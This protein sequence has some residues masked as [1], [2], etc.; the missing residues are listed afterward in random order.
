MYNNVISGN[1]CVISLH[2][3]SVLHNPLSVNMLYINE[4]W[5]FLTFIDWSSCLNKLWPILRTSSELTL[6]SRGR[7][8]FHM[9]DKRYLLQS[10]LL[11][12][13][14][15][16]IV[17]SKLELYYLSLIIPSLQICI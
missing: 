14:P 5:Y 12:V 16:L 9:R 11:R 1:A 10:I 8:T 4:D 17:S 15:A 3:H 2:I 6:F 7:D 13:M